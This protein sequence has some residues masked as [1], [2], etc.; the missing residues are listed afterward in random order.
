MKVQ[1]FAPPFCDHSLLDGEGRLTLPEGATLGTALKRLK[2]PPLVGRLLIVRVNYD[3][4][5]R[6]R[7]LKE[8]DVVS[9]LWPLSGG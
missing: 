7:K 3:R 1:V 9:L 2:L 6:S 5:G 8:G 4:A